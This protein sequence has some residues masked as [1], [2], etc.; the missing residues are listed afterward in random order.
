MRIDQSIWQRP[1]LKGT[2]NLILVMTILLILLTLLILTIVGLH[3]IFVRIEGLVKPAFEVIPHSELK[4][5]AEIAI[6]EAGGTDV[7]VKE[8]TTILS[9]LRTGPR[10][11]LFDYEN[12]EKNYPATVKL[13][14]LL[15]PKGYEYWVVEDKKGLPAHVT[16]RFG[17]HARYRY[18]W[19]FDPADMPLGE[20]EGVEH[21]S[22]AVY[23]S[24]KNE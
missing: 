18:I 16:I 22:G 12:D 1:G 4:K 17:T 10:D 20:I 6:K 11:G 14:A 23:L 8:A 2:P 21:L 5:R 24:E 3:H 15:S 9:Q 19:V 7:L 13:Q